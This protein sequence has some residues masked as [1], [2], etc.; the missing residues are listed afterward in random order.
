MSDLPIGKIG[1]LPLPEESPDTKKGV[2]GSGSSF[3]SVIDEALSKVSQ[4][5]EDVEKAVNELATGGDITDAV[6]AIEKAD[7]SFQLMVEI[8]NKL[9]LTYEEVMK[10][11]V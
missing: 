8:R 4:V 3:Q 10:M 6:L 1:S 9:I 5:Q 7:M 11:Q 2:P